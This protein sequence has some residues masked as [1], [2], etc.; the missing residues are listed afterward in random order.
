MTIVGLT[1][2]TLLNA[3][4]QHGHRVFKGNMN[5]N[6]IGVRNKNTDANTFNDVLCVLFQ[7]GNKWQLEQFACTTDPGT[8]YRKNPINVA[9]TAVLAAMQHKSLWTFGYHKGYKALVQNQPVT[10]YR[11]SDMDAAIN[12]DVSLDSVRTE[13]GYFGI[14]CHRAAKHC[15][16][17]RVDKW[18]AGCQVLASPN[19]FETLLTLC[20]Q[21]ASKYGN[22]FTYTL[23][24]QAN[25]K[26]EKE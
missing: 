11:D 5:L 14:N 10:V 16:S 15:T 13:R 4:T 7:K 8:Y 6:I 2:K 18:S 23:L 9:G 22:T 24:E 1:P 12:T 25:I 3:M 17:T 19:D 26:I 21:S 20:E